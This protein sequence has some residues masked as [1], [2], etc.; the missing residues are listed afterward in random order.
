MPR[1]V[2]LL[3]KPPLAPLVPLR[4]YYYLFLPLSQC[5]RELPEYRGY[6]APSIGVLLGVFLVGSTAFVCGIAAISIARE[7]A[8]ESASSRESAAYPFGL[9]PPSSSAA[10]LSGSAPPAV[11]AMMT[12]SGD[13]DEY[14]TLAADEN[15]ALVSRP[16]NDNNTNHSSSSTTGPDEVDNNP[17]VEEEGHVDPEKKKAAHSR[18]AGRARPSGRRRGRIGRSAAAAAEAHALPGPSPLAR[19]VLLFTRLICG[20]GMAA[21]LMMCAIVV[22]FAPH[23]PGVN[24]CNTEF[25]WVSENALL[26]MNT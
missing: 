8:K 3:L 16:A 2:D 1:D 10:A 26:Y 23:A 14:V 25:D 19:K 22:G 9:P 11:G 7:Y 12:T 21:A 15:S 4:L 20:A 5:Q 17:F 18:A 13:G 6:A 24:V